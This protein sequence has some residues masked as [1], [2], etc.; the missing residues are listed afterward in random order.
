[1][2]QIISSN[3]FNINSVDVKR[4]G[5]EEYIDDWEKHT[6]SLHYRDTNDQLYLKLMH[7]PVSIYPTGIMNIQINFETKNEEITQFY[8]ICQKIDQ[9]MVKSKNDILGDKIPHC[10]SL[11]QYEYKPLISTDNYVLIGLLFTNAFKKEGDQFK[12]TYDSG[13]HEVSQTILVHKD[14]VS[15]IVEFPIHI[16]LSEPF[17]YYVRLMCVQVCVY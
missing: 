2:Q 8:H 14:N 5:C 16:T 7:I 9:L 12:P 17:E 1:M 4:Y 6:G 3:K 13:D 11:Q 15:I 10:A